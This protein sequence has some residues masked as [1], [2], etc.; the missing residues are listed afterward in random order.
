ML[1]FL[2]EPDAATRIRQACVAHAGTGST[3]EIGS[4]IAAAVAG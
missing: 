1:D 3:S 4:E 2:G